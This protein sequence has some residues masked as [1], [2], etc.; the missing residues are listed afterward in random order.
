MNQ[1]STNRAGTALALLMLGIASL[2]LQ[3]HAQGWMA[4]GAIGVAKQQDYEVG[5]PISMRDDTDTASRISGGYLVTPTQGVIVS[6]IDFGTPQYAGP[7][8]GGFTDSL[9]AN[10]IDV[11]YFIGFTPGAQERVSLFG[12]VGVIRFNQDVT[13]TDATGTFKYKDD[14][15][16]FSL[17]LGTEINLGADGA[18]AWSLGVQYQLFKDVGETINSGHEYDREM[19]S[20]GVNYR[21]GHGGAN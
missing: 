19:I 21:F 17:G 18:P 4:G 6:L 2:P 15:T 13:L 10:G 20:V 11:S 7:S 8:F 5:G 12:T 3:A 9:D 1:T 14:G 16:S